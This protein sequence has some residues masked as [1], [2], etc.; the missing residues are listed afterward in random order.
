MNLRR[1]I[2]APR[3]AGPAIDPAGIRIDRRKPDAG[4]IAAPMRSP[5]SPE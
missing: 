2:A 1:I 4:A 3:I 5:P